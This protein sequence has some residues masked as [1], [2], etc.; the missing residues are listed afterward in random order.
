IVKASI[1]S[2]D[3]VYEYVSPFDDEETVSL[4]VKVRRVRKNE[5]RNDAPLRSQLSSLSRQLWIVLIILIFGLDQG[6]GAID[7]LDGTERGYQGRC[8]E[9]DKTRKKRITPTCLTEGKRGFEQTNTCYLTEVILFFKTLKEHFEGIQTALIKEIKEMKEVFDQMKAEVDQHAVDKKC[10]EIE[11][12]NLLLENYNLIVECMSKDVFY[13]ATNFV[14]TVSRF[15]D[16]YNAYT[17]AQKRIAE[18]EAKNSS[19]KNKIQ[20]DDHDEMIKHFSKLQVEHLNLQLKYQHLKERFGNKKSA[21]SSDAPAFDL[22][23]VIGKLEERLQGRGNAIR[24][25]K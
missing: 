2:R 10:D 4:Q 19:T 22:V 14:L 7:G 12:E 8:L 13:T 11:R 18:L 15:S 17:A 3:F 6:I 16:M 1:I 23:F 21:T 5:H 9:F 20:N 24:E 25:L